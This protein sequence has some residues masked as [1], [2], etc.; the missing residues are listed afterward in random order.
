[1]NIRRVKRID[2]PHIA[3]LQ[4]QSWKDSY[5]GVLPEAYLADQLAVDLARH[6]SKVEIQPDD[7]VRV[8]EAGEIIGFIAIWCRPDPYID[9]L[10]VIPS[11]RSKGIGSK[12]MESA[13][14]QLIRQGYRTAYLWVVASN[15]QA[16]R[17]YERL[18]GVRTEHALKD[19][20]GH[21]VPSV[22]VEWSDISS[23][24]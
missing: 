13:A 9:N 19:L 21:E 23:L 16:I 4:T 2:L 15:E 20:F 14:R 18:G 11:K 7:V 1:M 8:A 3:A 5:A 10:H 6:W 17:L 24:C 22:K 12:L